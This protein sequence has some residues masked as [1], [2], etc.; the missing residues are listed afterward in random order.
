M[1]KLFFFLSSIR[2]FMI[3]LALLGLVSLIGVVIPQDGEIEQYTQKYGSVFAAVITTCGWNHVFSSVGFTVALALFC[4]NLLF[5]IG[6]RV[7]IL[8]GHLIG[9][10]GAPTFPFW[11]IGVMG[12]LMLHVSLLFLVAGGIVQHYRGATL[13]VMLTEGEKQPAGTFG[14][15]IMLHDFVISRDALGAVANYQSELELLDKGKSLSRGTTKVNAPFVWKGYF[16]YQTMFGHLPNVIKQVSCIVT[17]STDDT[18][19]AGTLPFKKTVTLADSSLRVLCD[20]FEGDFVFDIQSGEVASRSREHANP[21]FHMVLFQN[22]SAIASHW[23]FLHYLGSQ[24]NFGGY[25]ITVASYDPAFYSGI[26]VRKKVGTGF[27]WTGITGVSLGL[28]LTFLFPFRRRTP[29]APP[30][31]TASVPE[32]SIA[33]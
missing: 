33:T 19:Y 4:V 24:T 20:Q 21:A 31:S 5:C 12:S 25:A 18:V 2:F 13:V 27:I 26:Q 11:N 16:F 7:S 28:M 17:D 14:F 1:R 3:I 22:D 6:N 9:A 15:D 10:S 8:T 30:D 23:I 29:K 32:N